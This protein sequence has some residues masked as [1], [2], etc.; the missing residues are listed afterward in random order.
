MK[1]PLTLATRGLLLILLVVALAFGITV[2]R[3]PLWLVDRQTDA[4]L[5][6]HGVRSEFVTVRGY[7]IHCLVGGSGRPLVLVHGLG[8]R[9]ADWANL[10]P[11]LI[12][13]G[14]RVYALDLLGY[15]LSERPRD[16]NYSIANQATIVEGFL[17]S[18]HLQQVDLAGW[19][20]GGWIAMR[21]A[22]QQPERIRRLVLLDSAGLRF[23]LG[24]DPALFQPSSPMELAA[25]EGLLVPHPPP[26]P[27]FLAMA[28]LRRGDRIGWVIHRSLRSMMTGDDLL[29][30]K[31]GA[32]T[33]PVLIGWGE[34]DR[35]IPLAVGY[36]LHA[37]ILQSVLDIY[38]GCGHLAPGQCVT[39]VGPSVVEFLNAQP[40][41]M[42]MVRM[43]PATR[44]P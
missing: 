26:L 34:Q 3:N 31:L 19:S 23:K 27:G 41:R 44:G 42:A 14:H 38:A 6:L 1:N 40:A 5:R 25:L 11:R 2:W 9:A 28:L 39:Q 13:G 15:G 16:A 17:D 24:F 21:V 8:S 35:L 7:R 4:R 43:I 33:M 10:I 36:K 22:L 29:D 37:Q 32:L 30:G 20:M 12:D 18:E